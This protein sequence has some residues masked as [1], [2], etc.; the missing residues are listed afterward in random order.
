M[1]RK[2]RQISKFM[3]AQTGAQITTINIASGISKSKGNNTKDFGQLIKLKLRN[4]FF[5]N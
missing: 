3:T 4:I 2:L 1:I 5:K